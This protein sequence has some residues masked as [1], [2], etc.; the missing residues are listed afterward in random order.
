MLRTRLFNASEQRRHERADSGWTIRDMPARHSGQRESASGSMALC[1]HQKQKVW[2][3]ALTHGLYSS[4]QQIGHE[5]S[6]TASR[7][8]PARGG[9]LVCGSCASRIRMIVRIASLSFAAIAAWMSPPYGASSSS[10]GGADD[11]VKCEAVWPARARAEPRR[12]REWR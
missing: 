2:P 1:R 3:H 4:S 8:A 10:W 5:K 7:A 11:M 9:L 12:R 6:S